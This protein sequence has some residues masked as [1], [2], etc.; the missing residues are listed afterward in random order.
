MGTRQRSTGT[1]LCGVELGHHG[2]SSLASQTAHGVGHRSRPRTPPSHGPQRSGLVRLRQYRPS[3][4][5]LEEISKFF[6]FFFK[7]FFFSCKHVN[8]SCLFQFVG[9]SF[10]LC[11]EFFY[12]SIV[13]SIQLI[14][15]PPLPLFCRRLIFLEYVV[16]WRLIK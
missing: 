4:S 5:T 13:Q 1:G 3:P 2:V 10:F 15:P 7:F 16:T 8:L 6:F 12:F 14:L 9:G 11:V